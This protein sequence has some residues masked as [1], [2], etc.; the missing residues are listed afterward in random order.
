MK[1]MYQILAI[2]AMAFYGSA[3]AADI[4]AGKQVAETQCAACHGADGNS[5]NPAWPKLAGQHASFIEQQLAMFKSGERHNDMMSPVAKGLSDSDAANVAAYYATQQSSTE[6]VDPE[7]VE[8]AQNLYRGG[9]TAKGIVACAACHGPSGAGN[10]GAK[11]PRIAGQHATY[12]ANRLGQY[13]QRGM[14]DNADPADMMG[15]I[16]AKLTQE[17]IE[18]LAAYVSAL[19]GE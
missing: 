4:A 17:Q 16:A 13:K 8:L 10:P 11:F 19:S 6:A 5:S 18:A 9:D 1:R 2:A 15:V 14:A 7:A 12:V 3:N